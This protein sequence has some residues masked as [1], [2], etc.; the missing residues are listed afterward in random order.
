[1]CVLAKSG[2]LHTF[3]RDLSQKSWTFL[4]FGWHVLRDFRLDV[5]RQHVL[6]NAS[7]LYYCPGARR[8]NVFVATWLIC[9][10]SRS[11]KIVDL[12]YASPTV[13]ISSPCEVFCLVFVSLVLML[14]RPRRFV[15]TTVLFLT[16]QLGGAFVK[17][18]RFVPR[19][20]T[21]FLSGQS[22]RKDDPELGGWLPRSH[23][24]Q[25]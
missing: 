4:S 16:E 14:R 20:V 12:L 7:L 25:H 10:R 18:K 11:T 5:L 13:T 1:M 15:T 19:P 21:V 22:W 17:K 6:R 2:Y 3:K 23:S 24:R 8:G 9:P